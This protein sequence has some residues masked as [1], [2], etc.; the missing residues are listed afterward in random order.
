MK[1][2]QTDCKTTGGKLVIIRPEN[3]EK[4]DSGKRLGIADIISQGDFHHT[5]SM[6]DE[7]EV[8]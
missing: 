8:E 3:V 6:L 4:V 7:I 5:W 2:R 1:I